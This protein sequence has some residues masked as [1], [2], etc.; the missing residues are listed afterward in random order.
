MSWRNGHVHTAIA[1]VRA[2]RW[3]SFLTMFGVIVG[4]ASVIVII[5][6][7]EGV[8]NQI[9][10]QVNSYS[11]NVITVESK[12]VNLSSFGVPQNPGVSTLTNQDV[13]SLEKL[14]DVTAS[15]PLIILSGIAT[16]DIAYRGGTIIAT[17]QDLPKVLNQ[18]LAFGS[19]FDT[20]ETN[21]FVA[22][23]G[24][25]ASLG[26]F[27]QKI[28]LGFSF[29]WRGQQFIVDGV[30]NKF[31]TTPF[32][33]NTLYNNTIFIPTGAAQEMSLMN[34]ASIFQILV[35]VDKSKDLSSVDHQITSTLLS[36]HGGQKNFSVLLPS[37]VSQSNT[38]VLNL[39]STL[40]IGIAIISLFVGGVGIMNV[41]LMSVTERMHEIGIR[42]AV[43]ATNRQ[44][45]SQFLVEAIT[46]SVVGGLIGI[47]L[48]LLADL[49][50][51]ATTNLTP[52][53]NWRV[54]LIGAAVSIIIGVLFGLIPAARAARKEPIDALR[55][56]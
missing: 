47:V 3:L 10:N 36:N 54:I 15:A 30:L 53:L 51:R 52:S 18:S 22:V 45:M 5:G 12:A 43:G 21:S 17:T 37:Q 26:L 20:N 4:V 19:F 33:N 34:G 38:S 29:S 56:E 1:A 8:K 46:I 49:A 25:N 23:L 42:K 6:I 31:K 13:T 50:L 27:N 32:S 7:S 55:N 40:S 16:G 28:P 24:Y 44:I 39:L 14:H 9:T 35:G 41:M 48:A 2:N 11:K